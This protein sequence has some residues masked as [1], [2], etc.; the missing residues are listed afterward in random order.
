MLARIISATIVLLLLF[1]CTERPQQDLQLPMVGVLPGYGQLSGH[2]SGSELDVLPVVYAYNEDINVGYTV[3]V[4]DGLYR[5]VN[6]IQG[7]YS[8]TIRPAVGQL[9]GFREQ[10][11][12]R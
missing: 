5:V 9:E 3:F 7:T 1:G 11:V 10:T 6:L 2:V 8:I 12:S 4:V